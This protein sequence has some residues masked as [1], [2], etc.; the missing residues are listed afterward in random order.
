MA[1]TAAARRTHFRTFTLILLASYALKSLLWEPFVSILSAAYEGSDPRWQFLTDHMSNRDLIP[2]DTYINKANTRTEEIQGMLLHFSYLVYFVLF[3]E[4]NFKKIAA[5]LLKRWREI[6]LHFCQPATAAHL[7]A[8]LLLLLP[9]A[10]STWMWVLLG[11]NTP[12]GAS[13]GAAVRDQSPGDGDYP[14]DRRD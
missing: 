2:L 10:Y 9:L 14:R 1:E 7:L 8:E 12:R 4:Q 11:T 5:W 3:L 6:R 13:Q